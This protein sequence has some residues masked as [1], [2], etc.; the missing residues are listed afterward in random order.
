MSEQRRPPKNDGRDFADAAW[1][2]PSHILSGM[3]IWGGAGWLLSRWTGVGAFTP[4]GLILGVGL[5][6]YLVYVK[7]GR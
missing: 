7:Y 2:I 5:A 1:S 6:I 4:I 3:V